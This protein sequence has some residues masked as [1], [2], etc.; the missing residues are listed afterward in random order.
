M[1]SQLGSNSSRGCVF[2]SGGSSEPRKYVLMHIH[3]HTHKYAYLYTSTHTHTH[4][5]T[6]THTHVDTNMHIRTLTC[7]STHTLLRRRGQSAPPAGMICCGPTACFGHEATACLCPRKRG[8]V[9][10]CVCEIT[11]GKKS[12]IDSLLNNCQFDCAL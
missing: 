7:M 3:A 5:H 10:S 12:R 4:T 9:C 11:M 8:Q 1:H 6:L 2:R